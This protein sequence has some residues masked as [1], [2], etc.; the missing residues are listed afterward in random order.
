MLHPV[1]ST[2]NNRQQKGGQHQYLLVVLDV[3][4]TLDKLCNFIGSVAS[5]QQIVHWSDSQGEAHE[6]SRVN[7]KCCKG[8]GSKKPG[9][10]SI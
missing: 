5:E 7:A 8:K 6:E 10:W 4:V 3:T 2:L 1:A 9:G